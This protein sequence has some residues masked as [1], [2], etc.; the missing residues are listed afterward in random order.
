MFK[1]DTLGRLYALHFRFLRYFSR[2]TAA[3]VATF[4]QANLTSSFLLAYREFVASAAQ[5][6]LHCE[7]PSD[8]SSLGAKRASSPFAKL[9]L[10]FFPTGR[11]RKS[12]DLGN[13]LAIDNQSK[14]CCGLGALFFSG[15]L[16]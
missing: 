16:A 1:F 13:R 2:L 9:M 5:I 14:A 15:F 10:K 3:M 4:Y 11:T 6:G 7:S 8:K 12:S